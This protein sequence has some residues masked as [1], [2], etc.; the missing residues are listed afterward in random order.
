MNK[1]SSTLFAVLWP[2]LMIFVPTWAA[3]AILPPAQ[4]APVWNPLDI[5]LQW[6]TSVPELF[7]YS[8]TFCCGALFTLGLCLYWQVRYPSAFFAA[9][10]FFASAMAG[11]SWTA[12]ARLW[13]GLGA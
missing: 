8:P 7:S 12:V 5:A 1:T 13:H 10:L 3:N 2:V 9:L 11:P 4:A 6:L